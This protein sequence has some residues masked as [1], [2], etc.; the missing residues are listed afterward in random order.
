LALPIRIHTMDR[1]SSLGIF[2]LFI[3]L[4]ID[5]PLDHSRQVP[6]SK[7]EESQTLQQSRPAIRSNS[8]YFEHDEIEAKPKTMLLIWGPI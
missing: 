3:G 5:A 8:K 7:G 4:R 1:K 6:L 2:L